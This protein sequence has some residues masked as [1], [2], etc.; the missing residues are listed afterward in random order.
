MR[1]EL[2]N[3]SKEHQDLY[4]K[5]DEFLLEIS[6]NKREINREHLIV[7]LK[8][9]LEFTENL[10]NNHFSEED[11]VFEKIETLTLD[12]E[13]LVLFNKIKSD[14]IEIRDKYQNIFKSFNSLSEVIDS[15]DINLDQKLK[16]ELLFPAYNLIATINHHAQ[17]ED[18]FFERYLDA[19]ISS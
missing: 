19:L 1:S 7:N 5:L 6:K 17:R 16:P 3:F 18:K 15:S 10:L 2:L 11:L 8:L 14:H 9:L 12:E 4:L 13:M